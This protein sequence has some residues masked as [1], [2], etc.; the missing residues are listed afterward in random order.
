MNVPF[1]LCAGVTL[2]SSLTSFG[3]SVA[4]VLGR[5]GETRGLALYTLVRSVALVTV[6]FLPLVPKCHEWI[7]PIAI[8]MIVVQ[9]GDAVVGMIIKDRMKTFGPAGTAVVNLAAL[10][11]LL[12]R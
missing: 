11:W 8:G 3:F 6:S 10:V 9:S 1:V 5:S 7:V 12:A 4:A 2:L